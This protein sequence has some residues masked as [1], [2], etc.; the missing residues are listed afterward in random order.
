VW[1]IPKDETKWR[2]PLTWSVSRIS[3][4]GTFTVY[5][6]PGDYWIIVDQGKEQ[7]FDAYDLDRAEDY[8]RERA[9]GGPH[10]SLKPGERNAIRLYVR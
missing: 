7:S 8:V 9:A 3:E 10:I 4:D 1:L 6:A 2:A 5:A